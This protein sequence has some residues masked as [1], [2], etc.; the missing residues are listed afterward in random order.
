M[1]KSFNNINSN[2]KFLTAEVLMRFRLILVCIIILWLSGCAGFPAT[3]SIIN[4]KVIGAASLEQYHRVKEG[5][6]YNPFIYDAIEQGV[7]EDDVRTG[8]LIFL[9]C[10]PI[11][12]GTALY[13][14][15]SPLG[16][17]LRRGD[18]VQIEA[19]ERGINPNKHNLLSQYYTRASTLS[20][21]I[22]RVY[23]TPDEMN[24]VQGSYI[25]RCKP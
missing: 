4:T 11:T 20:Q 25:I 9:Q 15:L 13:Y 7:T 2:L 5:R 22:K 10:S 12:D 24:Y 8:R 17:V 1:I 18:F 21:V 16:M 23:P 6:Y 3:G 14:A 19:G